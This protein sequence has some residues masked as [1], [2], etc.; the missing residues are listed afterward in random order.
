[1][2][3]PYLGVSPSFDA[4]TFIA[5]NAVVIGDVRLGP[6]SSVWYGAA[7]RGDVNWIRI[8]AQSNVQDNAVVHVTHGTAP[9]LIG[10]L[11]TVGHSAVVHG[12]TIEDACLIGIGAVILDHAVVGEGSLVGARA[13][14]TGGTRIP[15]RSLVVGAPARVVRELTDEEVASVRQNALNYVRYRGIVLGEEVPESNPFYSPRGD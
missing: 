11:V 2:I 3:E 9:T 13:L 10:D 14:V 8:G 4:S 15:P 7:I 1:M 5:E 12:C 6:Q